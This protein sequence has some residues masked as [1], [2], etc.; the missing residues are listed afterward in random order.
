MYF[1]IGPTPE[2]PNIILASPC[3]GRGAKSAAGVGEAVAESRE[4]ENQ[5]SLDLNPFAI[6][7][8]EL[9]KSRLELAG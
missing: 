6:T 9:Q 5:L 4:Q 1:V 7:R 2:D 8:K 3:S